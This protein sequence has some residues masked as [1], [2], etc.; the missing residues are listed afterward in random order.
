MKLAGKIGVGFGLVIAIAVALGAFAISN[1][2]WIQGD[3]G[4]LARELVP[5]VQV[6][7]N[8][9]RFSL[10]TMYNMRGYTL[11]ASQSFMDEEK[12]NLAEVN[13]YLG[14]AAALG[15]RYPRLIALR[16]SSAKAKTRVDEYSA[17]ADQ[18]VQV[19]TNIHDLQ[20]KQRASAS[21]FVQACYDFLNKTTVDLGTAIN[22]RQ[23]RTVQK[24][25][26]TQISL[27]DHIIS[28]G[29]A[30]QVGSLTSQITGDTATLQTALD[31]LGALAG[32][33]KDLKAITT[34][35]ADLA[36]LERITNAGNDYGQA[37]QSILDG[38]RQL[39]DL[40]GKLDSATQAVLDAAKEAALSAMQ[41]TDSISK[42]TVTRIASSI[43][44]LVAGLAAAALIGIGVALAITRSITKPLR[45]GVTF[46]QIIAAGDFTHHLDS[47]QKDE[48][49]ELAQALNSM[50][51]RLTEI[52]TAVQENAEKVASSSEEIS[53][54][55][56]RLAEGAQSQASTLEE[57]SASV[58]ELTAS[59]D[60][61][62]KHAQSQASAVEQGSSSMT[63]VQKSVEEVS[64]SLTEISGLAAKSVENA[65][66]GAKAVQQVV[67][68]INRIA[69]G[70]ERIGGIVD[71][72]SD[73]ADQ[74]NLLALNASIEAARAGE[75]GRG[76]AVVADE[77]S[78]LAD[79]SA[80]STKEIE[81]LIKESVKNVSEGVKTAMGS[82][83]AIE[84]IRDA[85]QRVRNMIE[86][87]SGSMSQQ[88]AA[89][90]LLTS[91]LS[92]VSDMSKSISAATEEQ[93][94]SA[95]QVSKAVED[96]N[97]VTQAAAS[98]AEEMSASTE[99]L[100]TMAQELQR[101]MAQFKTEGSNSARS[102][103]PTQLAIGG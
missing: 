14:D 33:A 74:T 96:V 26:L 20:E 77:V 69:T 86:T 73:I 67:E 19:T 76:F 51:D 30:L 9:E 97:D 91:A 100:S 37:T 70:S 43:I 31:R 48:V 39:I 94:T 3:A 59:V 17:M 32:M 25:L 75:N 98:A 79:R 103:A 1:M 18:A 56:Q 85:S 72:I 60:Q 5:T 93:S 28:L 36:T 23:S 24:N 8:I 52:V 64:S 12:K 21:T 40:N 81:N 53:T 99:Q 95:R 68:G 38:Q 34:D 78:K 11:S 65:M 15:A 4:R 16:N 41:D 63:Q 57:T 58:E 90:K 102:N 71:V 62:A 61:V 35:F 42:L 66:H 87:L 6:A 45:Q 2:L 83:A 55:A 101:L 54:S 88:V 84:Q 29:N 80:A 7:N 92:N 47:S 44:T 82:Q 49:G 46:A 13:T 27:I 89:V 10:L 22:N 50:V